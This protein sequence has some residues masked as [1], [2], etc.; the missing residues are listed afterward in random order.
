MKKPTADC[1]VH[2]L[3]IKQLLS[4]VL[5]CKDRIRFLKPGS[6]ILL[7]L[8]S[9]F[10]SPQIYGQ[11]RF[12]SNPAPGYEKRIGEYIDTLHIIDNHEHLDD[13]R[14]IRQTN[15]LDFMLLFLHYSHSDLVSAGMPK[16]YFDKLYN[17]ALPP[18]EKWSLIEPYFKN[19]F[20]TA[21]IRLALLSAEQLY[22]VDNIDINSVDTLSRRI[23]R[24][25]QTDWPNHVLKDLCR[26]DYLIQD[27]RE[28]LSGIDN[29]LYVKRFSS[30]LNVRSKFSIDSLAV[31]QV[32]PIYN[33][34]DFVAS[35]EDEFNSALKRGIVAVKINFA[36]N[37]TLKIENVETDNA[38]KVF[39]S[40]IN[41]NED[42][43]ITYAEAKPLQDYMFHRLMNI[44]KKTG[45]P[46]VFHTGFQAGNGNYIENSNP[47]LLSNIFLQYPG[48]NFALF[49]GSYPFGGEL[50]TLAKNFSNVY[51]DM[52]WVYAISPSY[53]ERYL[54]EWIETVPV[55]KIMAFGG[56][57]RC[58]E[59]I[60]S[61]LIVAKQIISD[62]LIKKVENGYF[63]EQEAL[64][65]ARLILHDNAQK[66]YN[67][68]Q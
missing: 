14:F 18:K 46:V 28:Q 48:I 15:F 43:Q 34:E 52:N 39:R 32:N 16:T 53:S 60:Y 23:Y 22:G 41:G 26:I 6:A 35:M 13:P 66:F 20:N 21:F 36:Y 59:N 55:S 24:A 47:D 5:A 12:R 9:F 64:T 19:S 10:C 65:V 29:V 68:R 57:Y 33:L 37:R 25:Y 51:I 8:L 45:L 54:N 49:H 61:E 38:M 63:S 7:A 3:R 62:V 2:P 44:V 42:K 67:I 56:D 1:N 50:A 40:L 4:V 27:S 11:Y 17:Q 58:V 31:M 30:W